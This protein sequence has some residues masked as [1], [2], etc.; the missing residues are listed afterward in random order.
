MMESMWYQLQHLVHSIWHKQSIID[1]TETQGINFLNAIIDSSKET[2]GLFP[3]EKIGFE[4][5]VSICPVSR[6]NVLVTD[7]SASEEDLVAFDE[8]DVEVIVVEKE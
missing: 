4:S 8:Q 6:L 2:I 1:I 5:V 7:W 3:T